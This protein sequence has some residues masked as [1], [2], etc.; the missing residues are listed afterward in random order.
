MNKPGS[1][2]IL[3]GVLGDTRRYRALHLAQQLRLAGVDCAVGHISDPQ[4]AKLAADARLLVLQRVGDTPLA[5]ALLDQ[6]HRN[7]GAALYDTDDLIFDPQAFQWIHSPD[8]KMAMRRR[9]YQQDMLL[10]RALLQACD[11]C[12]VST[13]YLA[14]LVRPVSGKPVWVHRNAANVEMAGI[15][16][17]FFTR[18]RAPDGRV[19]I[20]YAS[21]TPTHSR[22]FALAAPALRQMLRAHPQVELWVIGHLRLD[23]SWREFDDRVRA[24]PPVAWRD[25]PARL[26]DLDINLAP[27]AQDNP[28]SQSKSEIKWMEAALVGVPT[29]ASATDA[30]RFAIRDGGNGLLVHTDADWLPALE[31]LLD[32][33]FRER[34][35]AAARDAARAGYLPLQRARHAL[36]L[37]NNAAAELNLAERWEFRPLLK[38]SLGAYAFTAAEEK[39]PSLWQMGMYNGRYRGAGVLFKR[40]IIQARRFLA[41]WIPFKGAANDR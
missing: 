4:A 27:L 38:G 16:E 37:L 10:Q 21:G 11:G 41:R 19:I 24:V 18:R 29:V 7:G 22:D 40:V 9:L 23:D 30:F 15:S 13:D 35:G 26:A 31:R 33:D 32:T 6:V 14:G 1:I 25:L 12:L 39:E 28:F 34:L 20:G 36:D 17:T 5:H 8:F 2:L 3:S